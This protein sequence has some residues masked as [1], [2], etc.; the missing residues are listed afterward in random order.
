MADRASEP[1]PPTLHP[2]E[3]EEVVAFQWLARG[4]PGGHR[5][6][7]ALLDRV[8]GLPPGKTP[9]LDAA[10]LSARV[11]GK[12]PELARPAGLGA[13]RA[14]WILLITEA[15]SLARSAGDEDRGTRLRAL[16]L[17]LRALEKLQELDEV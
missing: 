17:R 4:A 10:V 13:Y 14:H 16:E 15:E 1:R 11:M 8:R 5:A 2:F 7:A 3:G 12:L 9:V 6:L